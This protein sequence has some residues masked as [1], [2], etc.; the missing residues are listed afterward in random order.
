MA[1]GDED[2]EQ[3]FRDAAYLEARRAR[4]HAARYSD[5]SDDQ[6]NDRYLDWIGRTGGGDSVEEDLLGEMERRG[7]IQADVMASAIIDVDINDRPITRADL[8]RESQALPEMALEAVL[9]RLRDRVAVDG[10]LVTWRDLFNPAPPTPTASRLQASASRSLAQNTIFSMAYGGAREPGAR[11]SDHSDPP[12][13][14][15]G[16]AAA[17]TISPVCQVQVETQAPEG[18]AWIRQIN[19]LVP[20]EE[21]M[22]MFAGR[23]L[24]PPVGS[25]SYWIQ[26]GTLMVVATAR[27]RR[28]VTRREPD[29]HDL[30]LYVYLPEDL[31]YPIREGALRQEYGWHARMRGAVSVWL[32]L[33]LD[34]RVIRACQDGRNELGIWLQRGGP[35][36]RRGHCAV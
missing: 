13:P 33:T 14:Q 18:T 9:Q 26:P 24:Q 22:A 5:L 11:A 4:A 23:Y 17:L 21:G 29:S 15:T 8:D 25:T 6:L 19:G 30:Q 35:G 3:S 31:W 20:D 12:P 27:R 28:G 10:D 7:M 1:S 32:P 16:L 36:R 34:G 2:N